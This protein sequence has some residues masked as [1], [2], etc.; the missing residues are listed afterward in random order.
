MERF[1]ARVWPARGGQD[2]DATE[3]KTDATAI[4]VVSDEPPPLDALDIGK[5]VGPPEL[6]WL[7]R[8]KDSALDSKYRKEVLRP[9]LPRQAWKVSLINGLVPVIFLPQVLAR[10]GGR[11][12]TA[13]YV[14]SSII[15]MNTS[16]GGFSAFYGHRLPL[17]IFEA[18][19][20]TWACVMSLVFQL[21]FAYRL[22]YTFGDETSRQTIVGNA[23]ADS[24]YYAEMMVRLVFTIATTGLFAAIELDHFLAFTTF[25]ILVGVSLE[26]AIPLPGER[27]LLMRSF[28]Y[29]IFT[30]WALLHARWHMVRVERGQ[31]HFKQSVI[32]GVREREE[33]LSSRAGDQARAE[34]AEGQRE[35]R[36]RLIRVVMHDLRSPLLAISTVSN[37]LLTA[38]PWERLDTPFVRD[39]HEAM[40]RC[41][42]Q[43]ENIVSDMLDF[44][45]VDSGRLQLVMSPFVVRV[46][47]ADAVAMFSAA[48]AEKDVLLLDEV[49]NSIRDMTVIGDSRRLQQCLNNGLSNSLKFTEPR[50]RVL[51]RAWQTPHPEASTGWINL[52]L[53]V[54]DEGTGITAQELEVLNHD[55]PFQQVGRGQLQGSGGTGLG[56]HISRQ[57]LKL[58]HASTLT[59]SSAGPGCGSTF[60]MKVCCR[61]ADAPA[62]QLIGGGSSVAAQLSSS[63]GGHGSRVSDTTSSAAAGAERQLARLMGVIRHSYDQARADANRSSVSAVY[64]ASAGD[65]ERCSTSSAGGRTTHVSDQPGGAPWRR[66]SAFTS[67]SHFSRAHTAEINLPTSAA[68]GSGAPAAE[69]AAPKASDGTHDHRSTNDTVEEEPPAS[70]TIPPRAAPKLRC[71]YAEDDAT[72]RM[73]IGNRVFAALDLEFD[74][75]SNGMEA[76]RLVRTNGPYDFILM[77]NQMPIMSGATATATIRQGEFSA[78]TNGTQPGTLIVGCTGDPPSSEDRREFEAAGLDECVDKDSAGLERIIER[79]RLLILAREGSPQRHRGIDDDMNVTDVAGESD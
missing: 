5:D 14:A 12:S 3:R 16:F 32:A 58:H 67:G 70:P 42:K 76:V 48:Y 65:A 78:V 73:V 30:I 2:G 47:I 61:R 55:E 35:A 41:S 22:A 7:G 8:F 64:R 77:D 36:S 59:L 75:A 79:L 6:T 52:H 11:M 46:L 62:I 69:T 18:I 27:A 51:L 39:S 4:H 15:V 19:F 71:L 37:H 54:D 23:T 38:D 34:R 28:V 45:R 49:P 26:V 10:T 68:L 44:E 66:S 25:S 57:L 56:L 74:V 33:L 50:S 53:S 9:L 43:M 31:F 21:L 24:G 20:M 72:L 40:A 60:E 29:Y 1:R 13:Q 17:G 63:P